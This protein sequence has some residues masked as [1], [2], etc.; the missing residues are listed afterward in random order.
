MK[1]IAV[2][3][4]LQSP[5]CDSPRDAALKFFERYPLRRRCTVAEGTLQGELFISALR[6]KKWFDVT[7]KV[8]PS[9]FEVQHEANTNI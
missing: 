3:G 9:L 5:I 8:I 1:Y 2:N 4:S 6:G 7:R